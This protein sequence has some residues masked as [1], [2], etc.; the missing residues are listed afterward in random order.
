MAKALRR[1]PVTIVTGFLGA[2]KSTLLNRILKN[3]E[4]RDCA[5]IINEFGDVGI[6]HLLVES[7]GDSIVDLSDGCVCCTVRG[8]LV[9]TLAELVD[10]MQ[11]GRIRPLRRVVIETTGLADPVPVMQSVMGNPVIA[12]HFGLQGV[13]TLVD[14]VHGGQTLARYPE[15]VRQVAVADRLVLTKTDLVSP[16]A[17]RHIEAILMALNPRA[18]LSSGAQDETATVALLDN[19]LYDPGEKSAD[20]CRWL[21][22]E[23]ERAHT[24]DRHDGHACGPDCTHDHH[25]DHGERFSRHSRS[26]GS[27]SILHDTPISPMALEMFVDLL[28]SAHGDKLLRMKAIVALSDDPERPVVLHGVQSVFHPPIRLSG[29]PDAADRRT[30]LVLITDGLEESFVR[31]LFDAFTGT[32]RIDRPDR[33]ALEDN[34]LAVPGRTF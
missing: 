28:R 1:I 27:F 6:D 3:P 26:I 8:E 22:E 10:R 31:D 34:P 29:W 32:P 14:A 13:I 18:L 5:V 17:V 23:A 21:G 4:M 24:V 9:D 7:S 25:H 11:T 20:V 15:A 33:A 19:G 30:R 12:Q 2:G 16:E